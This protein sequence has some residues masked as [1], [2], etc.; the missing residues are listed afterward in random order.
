[1]KNLKQKVAVL[2]TP[3]IVAIGTLGVSS[4]ASTLPAGAVS[5]QTQVPHIVKTLHGKIYSVGM[6]TATHGTFQIRVG[7][8]NYNVV[9][10][11]MTVFN[12]GK[13][14]NIKVGKYAT[15]KGNLSK[16][17]IFASLIDV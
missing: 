3:L 11:H 17:T 9:Y 16:S 4:L 14:S 13:A 15:V 10:D 8:K 7:T 6:H 5:H 12:M 1:M 2:A